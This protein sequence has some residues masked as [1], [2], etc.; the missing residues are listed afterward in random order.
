M[1]TLALKVRPPS[2]SKPNDH[3]LEKVN[4]INDTKT[5]ILAKYAKET[6]IICNFGICRDVN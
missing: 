4:A 5:P 3:F 1:S 6:G 2:L